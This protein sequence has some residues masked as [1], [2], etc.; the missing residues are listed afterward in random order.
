MGVRV[1][2]LLSWCLVAFAQRRPGWEQIGSLY[3]NRT[4]A[5]WT[6][7]EALVRDLR[8][9]NRGTRLK[10]VE[11][12]GADD[13]GFIADNF[14]EVS[15]RYAA[16]DARPMQDAIVQ[17]VVL[18]RAIVAV[19]VPEP[20]GWER[21]A[22][23]DGVWRY[24]KEPVLNHLVRIEFAEHDTPGAPV[25]FAPPA[26]ELVLRTNGGG[27]GIYQETEDCFCLRSGELQHIL[28][29]VNRLDSFIVGSGGMTLHERRWF[30]NN[31]LVEAKVTV[32]AAKVESDWDLTEPT[33]FKSVTCTPYKWDAAGFRYVK[34]GP[35]G[36]CHIEP[37]R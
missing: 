34:A 7:P 32:S 19:A 21:I 29:F 3:V 18:N 2:L 16:L 20:D 17:V 15:L 5:I 9:D 26:V 12:L 11:L 33:Q 22:V 25:R 1:L 23:I 4:R 31:Q 37:P 27:S 24:P 36:A 14:N 6:S 13:A 28:S 30:R 8:S 10:A 35:A